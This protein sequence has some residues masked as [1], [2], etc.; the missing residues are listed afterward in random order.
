MIGLDMKKSRSYQ[1][2]G[3][4]KMISGAS[5]FL[6]YPKATEAVMLAI[7]NRTGEEPLVDGTLTKLEQVVDPST[8]IR[9]SKKTIVEATDEKPSDKT[10]KDTQKTETTTSSATDTVPVP[11]GDQTNTVDPAL[12]PDSNEIPADFLGD[13]NAQDNTSLEDIQGVPV[14]D[15]VP[16][17][18]PAPPADAPPVQ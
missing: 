12:T 16:E 3:E 15:P 10:K 5:Y 13:P 2:P 14:P 1:I 11:E 9:D 17:A 8:I 18:A 6:H 4:A 7:Y